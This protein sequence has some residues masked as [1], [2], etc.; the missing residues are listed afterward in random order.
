LQ[1]RALDAVWDL[2]RPLDDKKLVFPSSGGGIINLSNFRN[3]VWRP[4]LEG[5]SLDYRPLYECRH[6]FA[7]LA[8]AAGVPLEW[9]SR[10]LGHA[11]TRITL[12]HYA[13]FLPA[14]DARALE[15]LD[16]FG[17]TGSDEGREM[18]AGLDG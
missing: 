5:A 10:Q 4:A 17:A 16:A 7:T 9:I 18:D 12:R 1:R 14:V 13:R 11:D 2:P 8:L 3:R 6:T 15:V